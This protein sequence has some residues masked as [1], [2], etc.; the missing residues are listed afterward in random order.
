MINTLM[1]AIRSALQGEFGEGFEVS[2]EEHPDREKP[3]FLI[4]WVN[5]TSEPS[6]GKRYSRQNEF[7]IVY[8][9]E[10]IGL[11]QECGE[12]ADRMF[13]CLEY[14]AVANDLFRGTNMRCERK[15]SSLEFFVNYPCSLYRTE[16][17]ARMEEVESEVT[18]RG[19]DAYVT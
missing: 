2:A 8:M 7:C 14:V 3:Y 18:M 19:G 12:V 16:N 1:E 10:N 4:R 9:P 11:Q 5:T 17:T 15:D 6:P 13:W